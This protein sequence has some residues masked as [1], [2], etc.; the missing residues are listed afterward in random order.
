MKNRW[1]KYAGI[2][3]AGILLLAALL[4]WDEVWFPGIVIGAGCVFALCQVIR[5]WRIWQAG[6][7]SRVAQQERFL[8]LLASLMGLCLAVGSALYLRAF[9]LESLLDP[10]PRP[11]FFVNAEYLFRSIFCSFDLFMLGIENNVFD[12]L[13]EYGMLRG[14]ISAMAV[15]S[16][17]CTVTLLFSLVRARIAAYYRFQRKTRID[18]AHNRLYVFFGMNE[19]SMLLARSIREKEGERARIIFVEKNSV[20]N[21]SHGGW[22]SIIGLFTHRRQTFA[23]VEEVDARVTFSETRLCDIEPTSAQHEDILG[24]LNLGK[25]REFLLQL[26][27]LPEAQLHIFFLSENTDENLRA[28]SA[29]AHDQ[30]VCAINSHITQRFYCHARANGLNRVIEDIAVTHGLEIRLV[31]SA[32]LAVELLKVDERSHPVQLMELDPENPATVKSAFQSLIVG[33]DEAGQDALRF[34]YEFSAVVDSSSASG[35]VQRAPFNCV[36]VDPRMEVL[37]GAFLAFTPAMKTQ[38]GIRLEQYDCRSDAFYTEILTPEYCKTLN[39]AVIAVGDDELGMTLAIRLINRIRTVRE[40]LSKLRIFVRSYRP[41]KEAFMQRIADHYNEGYNLDCP[42]A[43]RTPEILIP[44]GQKAKIYTYDMIVREELTI[45]GRRFQEAYAR[46]KGET[47]FWELRRKLLTGAC[48]KRK[49][50]EGKSVIEEVP[51]A[52]RKISLNN[53]RSLRRKESQDLANALHADT[54]LYL[55][56]RAMPADTDW[57]DFLQRYFGPD[58]CCPQCTGGFDKIVYSGLTDFENRVLLNLARTEHLRWNAS[59]EMLGYAPAPDGQ[60][61]CDERTRQHNC[62]RPWEELDAESRAVAQAEHW[63][64]DYKAFDFG[65]VDTTLYLYGKRLCS[66]RNR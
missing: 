32:R 13:S 28:M 17:S 4:F 49:D 10:D 23:G 54:K 14:A 44:F 12:T 36:A 35:T 20:D 5:R 57:N 59:H 1:M 41:D 33:F 53:L 65:V 52:D 46:M 66:S 43:Y 64:A 38:A 34:L 6:R 9:Y 26:P 18:A 62:L 42:E 27:A 60:H 24:L 16:F 8:W 51:V 50:A 15:L 48:R 45:G 40:D 55:L 19:P 25:L 3:A 11:F 29:L 30:T 7:R 63:A 58:G 31:D 2:G 37:K 21:E 39:C 22:E 47:E 56:R 61:G